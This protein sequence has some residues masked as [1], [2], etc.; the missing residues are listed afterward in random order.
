MSPTDNTGPSKTPSPDAVSSSASPPSPSCCEESEVRPELLPRE[1]DIVIFAHTPWESNFRVGS[2]FL[3]AEFAQRGHTVV[4]VEPGARR[5]P[6]S[7]VKFVADSVWVVKPS[8]IAR[9]LRYVSPGTRLDS[10]ISRRISS[11]VVKV[12]LRSPPVVIVDKVSMS[13]AATQI[14]SRR[15]VYRPTDYFGYASVPGLSSRER[16]LLQVSDVLITTSK[17]ILELLENDGLTFAG[18][19]FTIP[20]GVDLT[21]DWLPTGP[22]RRRSVVYVGAIDD[23]LD[24]ASVAEAALMLPNWQFAIGGVADSDRFNWPKNMKWLGPVDPTALASLLSMYEFGLLPFSDHPRNQARS[25]MKYYEYLAAGLVPVATPMRELRTREPQPLFYE[26]AGDLVETLSE[27]E[28]V[29]PQPPSRGSLQKHS[30]TKIA[31]TYLDTFQ[32]D[33]RQ[34]D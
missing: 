28:D 29:R 6:K 1:I 27:Y 13:S 15:L 18:P 33:L 2:H 4:Y 30:W 20:N 23:R 34:D 17:E 25:P 11:A 5:A 31:G 16:L 10:I 8:T 14:K 24:L 32:L 3:A 9:T 22:K 7:K 19:H 21:Q 26:T 12:G